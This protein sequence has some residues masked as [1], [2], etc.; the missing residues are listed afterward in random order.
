MVKS[1]QNRALRNSVFVGMMQGMTGSLGAIATLLLLT[2]A[3]YAEAASDAVDTG[4]QV[5]EAIAHRLSTIRNSHCIYVMDQ[6]RIVEQGTHHQLLKLS[7][8]YAG[9]WHVQLGQ[10]LDVADEDSIGAIA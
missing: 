7:G 5:V 2:P 6:G 1:Q 3:V 4:E 8:I 10:K 9:L